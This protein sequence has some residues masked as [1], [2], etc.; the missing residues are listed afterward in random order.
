MTLTRTHAA[1]GRDGARPVS[2]PA[3]SPSR[4]EL[5]PAT[6]WRCGG[7]QCGAAQCENDEGTL[8]RHASGPGPG[9]Q[10]APPIV[11]RVLRSS[12]SP[13]PDGVRRGL[14]VRTGHTLRN[15]RVHTDAEAVRS[16]RA[17]HAAAY[18]VGDQIV[19]GEGRFRPDTL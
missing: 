18:T 17:V 15:V 13:L 8:R 10:H 14:E 11:H 5:D 1:P 3:T 16:A 6:L 4:T 9:P 12:G 19:F 7:C 2:L